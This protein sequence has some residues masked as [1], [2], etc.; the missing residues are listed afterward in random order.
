MKPS[1]IGSLSSHS[2]SDIL[3]V[4]TALYEA[5]IPHESFIL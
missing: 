5:F 4:T 2:R 3:K 1:Q